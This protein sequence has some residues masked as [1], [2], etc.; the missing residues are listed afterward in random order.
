MKI[1]MVTRKFAPESSGSSGTEKYINDLCGNLSREH[2]IIIVFAHKDPMLKN[3][4]VVQEQYGNIK[5]IRIICNHTPFMNILKDPLFYVRDKDIE[6][7]FEGILG[8]EK[9]DIVHVHNLGYLSMGIIGVVNAKHIPVVVTLHDYGFICTQYHRYTYISRTPASKSQNTCRMMSKDCA[10]CFYG[11]YRDEIEEALAYGLGNVL[12][13]IFSRFLLL[14]NTIRGLT[15]SRIL[16]MRLA[17][18]K[19]ELEK[20]DLLIAPSNSVKEIYSLYVNNKIMVIP[21][22]IDYGK[23]KKKPYS[24]GK[25]VRFGFMGGLLFHKGADL[26]LRTF[27]SLAGDPAELYFYGSDLRSKDERSRIRGYQNI[28][29]I[30]FLGIFKDVNEVFDNIDV[31]IVPSIF[32]ETFSIA[33]H[34]A[35]AAG[36]PVIASNSGPFPEYIKHNINGLLFRPNDEVDLREKICSIIHDPVLIQKFTENLPKVKSISI[37]AREIADIYVDL[38]KEK[39]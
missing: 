26:L 22:G 13:A 12:A 7:I 34:E 18:A 15:T 21:H 33:A 29:N 6:T 35:F 19:L 27:S 8:T 32:E 4:S 16:E 23:I 25:T 11:L 9:P 14:M 30:K 31:L 38:I 10:P 17:Y 36:I 5:L 1:I 24:A 3:H 39:D 20:A 37:H 2:D 28:S